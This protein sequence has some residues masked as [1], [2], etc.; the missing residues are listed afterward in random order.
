MRIENPFAA[1]RPL[2]LLKKNC[3]SGHGLLFRREIL[4]WTL[5]FDGRM[6]FDRQLAIA[7]SLL[8]GLVF[9]PEPLVCHRIHDNNLTN[10]RFSKYNPTKNKPLKKTNSTARLERKNER[11]DEELGKLH[12]ACN[13]LTNLNNAQLAATGVPRAEDFRAALIPLVSVMEKKGSGF[14][15]LDL[16]LALLKFDRCHQHYGLKRIIRLCKGPRWHQL[17]NARDV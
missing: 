1:T 15:N 5:P 12:L 9:Y 8:G 17:F 16:F 10:H 3:V 14:F 7:A 2:A 13:I 6:E 11:Y 4:S